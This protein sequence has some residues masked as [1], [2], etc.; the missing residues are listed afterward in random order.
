MELTEGILEDYRE[1]TTRYVAA[2]QKLRELLPRVTNLSKAENLPAPRVLKQMLR[3][4]DKTE[5]EI[6]AA[7]VGFRQ[8]RHKLLRLI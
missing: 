1:L 6:E 4:F 7:L 3:D 8:I 2:S 5:E